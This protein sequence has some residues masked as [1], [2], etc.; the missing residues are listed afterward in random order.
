MAFPEDALFVEELTLIPN[1]AEVTNQKKRHV[2]V[3]Y[4]NERQACVMLMYVV[5]LVLDLWPRLA[6]PNKRIFLYS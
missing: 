2:F 4:P 6:K 5:F 3:S 1:S